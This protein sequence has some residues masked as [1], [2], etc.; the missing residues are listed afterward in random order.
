MT[1]AAPF[2]RWDGDDLLVAVRVQPKAA[3]DAVAE[4]NG[5][6]LKVRTTAPPTDGKANKHL[7]QFLAR[8]LGLPKSGAR[9]EKGEKAKDKTVR[10]VGA[11]P[12]ALA[13][14]RQRWGI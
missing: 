2:A 11:D 4:L 12:E 14:A 1:D 3:Q 13:S 10:L 5:N 8:E 9:V 7:A 6:A